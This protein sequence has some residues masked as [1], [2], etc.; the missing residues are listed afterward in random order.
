MKKT[1]LFLIIL[2]LL[3]IAGAL[4]CEAFSRHL[5]P[6][7]I[8]KRA[9]K[10]ATAAGVVDVNDFAGYGNLA[11]AIKLEK[12]VRDAYQINQL[13]I[14]QLA[15]DNDMEF[16][17]LND[18][19]TTNR[20]AGFKSEEKLFGE[21][22][23]LPLALGLTGFG[24]LGG[25]IGLMRKRPGDITPQELKT[26]IDGEG[27]KL[28]EK[29]K[30]FGELVAGV[31]SILERETA[32]TAKAMKNELAKAQSQSTKEAIAILKA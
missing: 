21:T 1:N 22:G 29:E 13:D 3:A 26:A 24:G 10:Y 28:T 6:A 12:G 5:T 14:A 27:A 9:V 11:K 15:A 19:T 16:A 17:Q 18:I 31:Q 30:Q 8:D 20:I 4:G 32:E 7:A 23:I 2:C 25:L